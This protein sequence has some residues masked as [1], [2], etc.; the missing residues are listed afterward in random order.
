MPKINKN[1]IFLSLHTGD[2]IST[3]EIPLSSFAATN[4]VHVKYAGEEH[5]ISLQDKV[6][7][8]E[9]SDS[10]SVDVELCTDRELDLI[11]ITATGDVQIEATAKVGIVVTAKNAKLQ[12]VICPNLCVESEQQVTLQ[13]TQNEFLM[14]IADK[15]FCAAELDSSSIRTEII[16]AKVNHL[17]SNCN[18]N[19]NEQY[20]GPKADK[21]AYSIH[22]D[23]NDFVVE[24]QKA[25][26]THPRS[27]IEATNI[28]LFEGKKIIA[29]VLDLQAKETMHFAGKFSIKDLVIKAKSLIVTT[30]ATFDQLKSLGI[31]AQSIIIKGKMFADNIVVKTDKLLVDSKGELYAKERLSINSSFYTWISPGGQ[32]R[33]SSGLDIA[34]GFYMNFCGLLRSYDAYV[35]SFIPLD[36]GMTLPDFPAKFKDITNTAKIIVALRLVANSIFKP[37]GVLLKIAH[38]VHSV[39]KKSQKI[40]SN[41]ETHPQKAELDQTY[42]NILNIMLGIKA[43]CFAAVTIYSAREMLLP[44][45]HPD[46]PQYSAPEFG[47]SSLYHATPGF[48]PAYVADSVVGGYFGMIVTGSFVPTDVYSEVQANIFSIYNP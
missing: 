38:K 48:L 17:Y 44:K 13:D 26:Q 20:T 31:Y 6:L 41:Y 12:N 36:V 28:S 1:S 21:A 15:L 16:Y 45:D 35:D 11:C 30:A 5:K 27:H 24:L 10:C 14:V 37:L 23:K 43:I 3:K 42:I 34:T 29:K 32:L 33:G 7:T 2:T 18:L 39:Y 8:V 22:K 25:V 40:Y 46:A 4:V 19:L 47:M 9:T